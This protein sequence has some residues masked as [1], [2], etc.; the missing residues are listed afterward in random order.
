MS[1]SPIPS[2]YTF[3]YKETIDIP[4]TAI[5]NSKVINSTQ[6]NTTSKSNEDE[7]N[8]LTTKA[9]AL[10]FL[11]RFYGTARKGLSV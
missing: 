8:C 3:T 5:I 11:F 6:S 1:K 9:L 10:P 2:K 4:A 7:S